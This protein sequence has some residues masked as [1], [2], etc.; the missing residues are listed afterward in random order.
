MKDFLLHMLLMRDEYIES[1]RE[2]Y[3]IR[4]LLE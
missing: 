1:K 4:I 2:Y 3:Q